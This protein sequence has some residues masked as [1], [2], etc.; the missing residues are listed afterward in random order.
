MKIK[1]FPLIIFFIVYILL[2]ATLPQN[3]KLPL[4]YF[5]PLLL[6]T[7]FISKAMFYYMKNK[8]QDDDMEVNEIASTVTYFDKKKIDEQKIQISFND[9][10]GL[11]EIKED[12]MDIID[13]WIMKINTG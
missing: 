1:Y 9:V 2:F 5:T 3:I 8:K 7:M 13:F 11:E 4:L 12:L 6:Y 10:A